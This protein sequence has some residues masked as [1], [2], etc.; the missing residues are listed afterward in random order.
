LIYSGWALGTATDAD[1]GRGR[2]PQ[3]EC[4]VVVP[5]GGGRHLPA[6]TLGSTGLYASVQPASGFSRGLDG[7]GGRAGRR[8]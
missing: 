2:I 5:G 4:T 8:R 1:A 6:V 7:P 3:E